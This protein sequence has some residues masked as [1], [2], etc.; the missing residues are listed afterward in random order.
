MAKQV[1]DFQSYPMDFN[2]SIP[3]DFVRGKTILL[4]GGASGFGA[5]FFSRWASQ[6][7][8]VIIGDINTAAGTALV[9][10]VREETKN[11]NLH[12]L[13]L[14]VTS[15]PSQVEFFREA[16]KLS[17][18]GGIDT[19]VANA[20]INKLDESRGFETPTIDYQTH[21][22]PPAPSFTTIDVNLTGTLYTVHLALSYLPKNPGST[23][24]SANPSSEVA[25]RDR[26]ILLLGSIAGMIPLTSQIPYCI[27]KHGVMGLFR[28]LRNTAPIS[29]G[30]RVNML[31]PYFVD[32][33]I[34][35][36]P[37]KVFMSGVALADIEHVIDAGS[38]FVADPRCVGRSVAIAPKL[39][40]RSPL[41]G[42][43]DGI[44][45]ERIPG[46]GGS[47]GVPDEV[48]IY[49]LTPAGNEGGAQREVRDIAIWEVYV[50]DADEMEMFGRRMVNIL[51]ATTRIRG[52]VMFVV[53]LMTGF[54][55]ILR[56]M[57]G[58][59]GKGK[60]KKKEC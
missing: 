25:E 30:I 37:G 54:A 42:G 57:C 58:D 48:D 45:A 34:L 47:S 53:D 12:F 20:G 55:E 1:Q 3:A 29:L 38:R 2:A 24:C 40:V 56:K 44:V 10:R 22:N 59:D 41:S 4:T 51:L 33:P 18:H 9:A 52:W 27:S 49:D 6:G 11:P 17:P 28:T 43:G 5:R 31:C 26:H 36:T 21:P 8:T 35:G 23:R 39:R 7:A 15:W 13:P 19:V 14:D 46:M 32:T 60:G 50:H 16:A